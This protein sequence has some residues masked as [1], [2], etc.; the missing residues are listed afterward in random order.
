MNKNGL[1][2]LIRNWKLGLHLLLGTYRFG[3][4]NDWWSPFDSMFGI[5]LAD[6]TPERILENFRRMKFRSKIGFVDGKTY[7][8]LFR[9]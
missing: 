5:P 1:L 2:Y 7:S 6:R 9:T 4:N 8:D 3:V